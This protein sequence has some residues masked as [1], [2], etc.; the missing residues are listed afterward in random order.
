M[1]EKEN[2][3]AGKYPI[4]AA[5]LGLLLAGAFIP[6]PLY[7]FYRREWGLSPAAISGVFAIYAGSLIPS[8]L[9][10]GGISDQIGR[11][12][13]LL[14]AI[15][16]AA[17]ASA[18]LAF[19]SNLWGLLM[20]RVLQGVSLGVGVSTAAAAVREWMDDAMRPRAGAVT[21]IGTTIGSAFGATLS[22]VLAQYAPY[23][24][25]LPYLLHILLL[26]GI[27]AVV[28]RVPACPHIGPAAHRGLPAIPRAIRRPFYLA[29]VESL[30][31]WA[32]FAIFISLLPSFLIRALNL[33]TLLVGTFVVIALMTGSVTALFAARRMGDRVA[34]V[35]GMLALGGGTWLLLLAIPYHQYALVAL[36]TLI[37]GVGGGLSYLSGLNIVNTI[38]PPDHRAE[39][40]SAFLVA[41]YLGFS[42][43][44]LGV[45]IAANFVGLYD[46]IVGAAV[47]LGI[48]A[49]ATMLLTTE[50]N[51]RPATVV[52][53]RAD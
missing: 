51:L 52:S 47:L 16:I 34:I 32:T 46:A 30:L 7:E 20:G 24:T 11:R 23:P 53:L 14:I 5:A 37:V 25:K 9:F 50:P 3:A 36:A 18:V 31:G 49:V 40:L 43:P 21:L 17:L 22:G 38:A 42:I 10:L 41:C 12:K 29:S 44:V 6:T 45:G 26:G 39:L 33:H 2:S 15:V 8:L 28:A 35:A 27:A 19:A 48:V 1:G 4:A 13:T